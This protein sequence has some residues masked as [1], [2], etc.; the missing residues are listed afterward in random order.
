LVIGIR[1]ARPVTHQA[2]SHREPAPLVHGW[3]LVFGY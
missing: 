2:A 1:N 3:K